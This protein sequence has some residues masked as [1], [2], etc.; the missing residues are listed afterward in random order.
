LLQSSDIWPGMSKDERKAFGVANVRVW[1]L[2]YYRLTLHL[3]YRKGLANPARIFM[4][5]FIIIDRQ[6]KSW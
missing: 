2:T 6:K 5:N 3:F 4:M 1:P